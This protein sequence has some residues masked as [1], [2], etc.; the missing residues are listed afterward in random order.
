MNVQAAVDTA[1]RGSPETAAAPLKTQP[2]RPA[3]KAAPDGQEQPAAQ[4]EP[5]PE[6]VAQAMN[7]VNGFLASGHS[8]IQFALHEKAER[9]MVEVIDNE[10]QEVIKTIPSKELLDLAARIGELVGTTLDRRG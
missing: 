5:R 3:P 4:T 6:E 7:G 10:T 1:I 2:V 8:H 9:M